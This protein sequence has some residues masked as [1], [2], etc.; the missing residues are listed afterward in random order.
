LKAVPFAAGVILLFLAWAVNQVSVPIP[1][2]NWWDGIPIP[3]IQWVN[4]LG[5]LVLPSMLIGSI[6]IV[7]GLTE[8]DKLRIILTIII[9]IATYLFL[10]GFT[11]PIPWGATP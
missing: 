9:V 1:G 5:F 7:F 6:L 8:N 10:R 11:F 4:P 3:T 2:V